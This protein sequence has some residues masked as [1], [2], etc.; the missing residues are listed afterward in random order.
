MCRSDVADARR[1]VAG[2]QT[3]PRV[4]RISEWFRRILLTTFWKL[5]VLFQLL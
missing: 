1:Y 2:P 3:L 5:S 4:Q